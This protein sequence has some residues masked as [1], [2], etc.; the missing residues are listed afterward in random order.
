MSES[1]EQRRDNEKTYHRFFGF[2]FN[3]RR[4]F[5]GRLFFALSA[6]YFSLAAFVDRRRDSRP[7]RRRRS[8]FKQEAESTPVRKVYRQP[9]LLPR[10]RRG[11]GVLY[12]RV[13][14]IPSL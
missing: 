4:Q 6:V 7:L 14:H 13:V 10:Q 9:D 5:Y 8:S 1:N 12:P 3:P 11:A 2:F